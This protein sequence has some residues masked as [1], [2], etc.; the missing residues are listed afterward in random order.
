MME[1]FRFIAWQWN[2]SRNDDKT[3][4]LLAIILGMFVPTAFY[5]GMA[6]GLVI[7]LA[8]SIAL[9]TAFLYV[10]CEAIAK[11]WGMY[12]KAQE[13]E[14]QEIVDRLRGSRNGVGTNC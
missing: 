5:M 4:F 2:R 6:F 7:A 11:R 14:A 13:R 8:V 9:V 10:L 1:M 12:K 3:L